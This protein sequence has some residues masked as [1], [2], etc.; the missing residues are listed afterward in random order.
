MRIQVLIK[1]LMI[2]ATDESFISYGLRQDIGDA[3][4]LGIDE[5]SGVVTLLDAPDYESKSIYSFIAVV[6]DA[7]GNTSE[8]IVT[9]VI[10]DLDENAPVFVSSAEAIAVNENIGA[11]QFVYAAE[12]TDE[13][14]IIYSV[15]PGA[16]DASAFSIDELSGAVTLLANPDY[17]LKSSYAFTVVATDAAGNTA[18]HD[19]TLAINDLDDN[20]PVFVSSASSA[21]NENTGEQQVIYTAEATDESGI[22]YGIKPGLGDAYAFSIDEASGD[23]TLVGDP[24]YESKSSYTFTVTATDAAGN[25]AEQ[26]VTLV[27]NDLEERPAPPS[28]P[29]LS[30]DTDSGVSNNDNLTNDSTPTFR[31]TAEPS[32]S[33]ELF[34]D[35]ISIGTTS[36]DSG[37]NWT[38]TIPEGSALGDGSHVITAIASDESAS[39]IVQR[40]PIAVAI[41]G[42]TYQEF[43]HSSAFAALKEDGFVTWG[44][45]YNGGDSSAVSEEL[46]SGVTQIFS[47]SYSFAA[48][49]EDGSVVTWGTWRE[50]GD[51]GGDSSAVSGELQAGVTQI[52]STSIAFAALKEDGSVI[53]WGHLYGGGDSRSVSEELQSGVTQIFSTYGAFA[54]LKEDGS[55]VTWGRSEYGGDS[56]AVSAALQSGVTQIFSNVYAFA[57][58]KEDGSVVT[59][60]DPY[61][62][63]NSSG[64]SAE[65]QSGVTQL[66]STDY[67]FA[68]LKDDGSVV[69]WNS[70]SDGGD[71]SA[72]SAELQSGVTQIFSSRGAFAALKED[73]SVV[74]WGDSSYDAG[75]SSAVSAELQSGVTQIFSTRSAFAAL[76][77]DGS[78]VT[79]GYL[80]S[81]G[82]SRSVS[83]E[84]QSGVTQ[85]FS[86]SA[87]FAALKEDGSVVTWGNSAKGGDGRIWAYDSGDYLQSTGNVSSELQSGVTQIF[88]THNAFAA[89]KEDGSVVTWGRSE[90]GGDS[91]AVSS[92]LQSGVV[93][94][95]DPFHDDRLIPA[96]TGSGLSSEPSPALAITI[97]TT[98][99]MFTSEGTA[100]AIDENT[101]SGQVVYTAVATDTSDI[102]YSLRSEN[103]NDSESFSIESMTGEV[104]LTTD[105]DYE[106]Q[107]SYDFTIVAT[108]VAGNIAEQEVT[109]P[110]NDLPEIVHNHAPSGELLITGVPRSGVTITLDAATIT[111]ED[112]I[113][114]G[115]TYGWQ[116][117]DGDTDTWLELTSPDSTDG[118]ASYTLTNDDEGEL[119]RAQVSYVDGNGLTETIS[120]ELFLVESIDAV[121]DTYQSVV[122]RSE[123][124]A[125]R[126]GGSIHLPLIYN[127]STGNANLPGLTLNLHYDSTLLAPEGADHGVSGMIDA[128]I[129]TTADLQDIDDLDNNPLTDRM[130]QLIWVSFDN[131]FPDQELPLQLG[132]VSFESLDDPSAPID[133]LTGSRITF[134][135]SGTASGYDFLPSTTTLTPR[136]FDLDVD[137]DGEVTA[138]GDGLMIIRK[139]LGPA[140][141]GDKLT[142]KAISPEATRTTEEIHEFIQDG[143]NAGDLDVDQDGNTTALGDGLM[144]IRRLKIW[145]GLCRR[146]AY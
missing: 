33:V 109:L 4:A 32:T 52:F 64:V 55:A 65:L 50:N 39:A 124:M 119:L 117:F 97:D 136:G 53:T 89:L 36:A 146:Q 115:F 34:D 43:G 106:S 45:S 99:P 59:W 60:G 6:A 74:T 132:N 30:Q 91:S 83:A 7:V 108:D 22:A 63:G 113:D 2:E 129:T 25:A 98:A 139:L 107:A 126:P 84:L 133:S 105:P 31:G 127:V 24:D 116:V 123:E 40:T 144:V 80:Y 137:G 38:Y 56:S 16:G 68:A 121:S 77:E 35:A 93:S 145:T 103:N 48:L 42:R 13:S 8:Q 37:G 62:G 114:S 44:D 101:A 61:F 134:T 28:Q 135:A 1:L 122:T 69:T 11:E 92:E 130:V 58:L 27:I 102:T 100:A 49:K 79:W 72:V 9:L 23:V 95:A 110:I 17:E 120:S 118:D 86:T 15:K 142:D 143:I 5:I 19:V 57:A 3:F 81:G 21:I 141:A 111:D 138:L 131:S 87:A 46:Q 128:A 76:K 70:R 85:I 140:F 82:D 67:A 41:Q 47:G 75:D 94:F 125:Y 73:G 14:S 18:E 104:R 90:Y 96:A 20:A 29:D 51:A 54:A 88:S 10:N 12:A 112:G 71:I 66:F 78:V 26:D